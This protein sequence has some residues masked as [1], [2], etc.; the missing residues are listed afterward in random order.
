MLFSARHTNEPLVIDLLVVDGFSLM[1]LAATMEPLRAANRVSGRALYDWRLLSPDG[2][3]VLGSSGISLPL[4]GGLDP[5]PARDARIVVAAFA[6]QIRA[7]GLAP[8]HVD[9]A[10]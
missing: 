5:M 4:T 3:P 9:I 1:S 2:P 6:A 10:S 7:T 8:R